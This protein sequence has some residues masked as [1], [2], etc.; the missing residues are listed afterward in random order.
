MEIVTNT[1]SND[2]T[3]NSVIKNTWSKFYNHITSYEVI[4]KQITSK[5]NKKLLIDFYN[6][7]CTI[8]KE[9]N[10]KINT[11]D[12]MDKKVEKEIKD[13]INNLIQQYLIINLTGIKNI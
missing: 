5:R 7:S 1:F 11:L 6:Q 2:I 13:F 9:M 12:M 3:I 4:K 10:S 8:L